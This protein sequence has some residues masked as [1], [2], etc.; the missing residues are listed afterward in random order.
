MNENKIRILQRY[1]RA[2]L[3]FFFNKSEIM[4]KN[5]ENLIL[6]IFNKSSFMINQKKSN[7]K[8]THQIFSRQVFD[9][10]RTKELLNFLQK[11]F[12][13]QMFFIHNRFYLLGYLLKLKKTIKGS[14]WKKLLLED[15]VG[16]PVRYFLYPK[17]SGNK[18]FQTFHLKKFD[19]FSNI[20]LKKFSDVI[21][22]GGGYGNMAST[23]KRINPKVN[24]TIF[25]TYEVNLLQ[26]YYLKRLNY[27]VFLNNNKQKEAIYLINSLK[28]LK[29][30]LSTLKNKSN[31]LFI[32]NWSISETPL[33]FRK[34]IS[35]LFENFDYQLISFQSE[36]EKIDNYE[37]FLKIQINNNKKNRNS[38]LI[39]V[40]SMK[41]HF[42]LFSKIN[43]S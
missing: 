1:L 29:L 41:N 30:K 5:K 2:K 18:I 10:I 23:F 22:F 42:Y 7:R 4:D 37:Y 12:I 14:F 3:S 32:A 6:D 24:Y 16:N 43:K 17:S 20:N 36:F 13:Q 38:K 21:E 31:K 11:S 19:D 25:D 26:Y 33:E 35:F 27:Q 40:E 8:K 15:K 28:E 34:K 9:L 39:S